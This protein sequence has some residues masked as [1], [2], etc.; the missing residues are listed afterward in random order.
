MGAIKSTKNNAVAISK[1]YEQDNGKK[2]SATVTF[3]A[4]PADGNYITLNGTKFTFRDSPS[5]TND[6]QTGST[7]SESID[8]LLTEAL[9][10]VATYTKVDTDK[11]Y[12]EYKTVGTDGNN[13]TIEADFTSVP[14]S[15]SG[16]SDTPDGDWVD[17]TPSID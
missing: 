17:N 5:D 9:P 12:I 3:G 13:Y 16:G 4:N 11:I 1:C 10:D 15:L 2:A 8:N 14:D 6:V 7:I